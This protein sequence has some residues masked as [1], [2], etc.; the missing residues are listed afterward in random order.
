MSEALRHAE[1][2]DEHLCTAK[3]HRLRARTRL[4][5]EARACDFAEAALQMALGD[6][7]G[8]FSRIFELR[9][10]VDMAR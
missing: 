1:A 3:L 6:A 8:R 7:R 4:A 9:A 2:N 10:V 5:I